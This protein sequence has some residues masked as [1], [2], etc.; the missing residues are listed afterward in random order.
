MIRIACFFLALLSFVPAAIAQNSA[1][2]WPSRQITI[3]V[4]F[5]AGAL[6]DAAARIL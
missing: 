1:Q 2:G 3:I 4:P 5:P 6:S